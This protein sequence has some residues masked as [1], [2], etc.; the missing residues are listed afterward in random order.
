MLKIRL[1][2]VGRRHQHYFRIVLCDARAQ[3]DGVVLHELGHYNPLAK[4]GQNVSIKDLELVKAWLAKGAQPTGTVVTLLKKLGVGVRAEQH[5]K[6]LVLI[7]KKKEKRKKSLGKLTAEQKAKR[8]AARKA[9]EAKKLEAT[10]RLNAKKHA[11][12]K[13][14]KAAAGAP[15]EKK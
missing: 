14:K 10:K 15:A 8:I 2:M 1:K 5:K 12:A 9:R 4:D 3:R 11:K 13:A 7:K 6:D